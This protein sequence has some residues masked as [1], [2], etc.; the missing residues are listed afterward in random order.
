LI[1]LF[2]GFVALENMIF[3][4]REGVVKVWVNE[5][6]ADSW[7]QYPHPAITEEEFVGSLLNHIFTKVEGESNGVYE[8]IKMGSVTFSE[9]LAKLKSS[10]EGGDSPLTIGL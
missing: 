10:I 5:N 6:L 1:K 4:N 2:G 8:Y 9:V 7:I 3:V